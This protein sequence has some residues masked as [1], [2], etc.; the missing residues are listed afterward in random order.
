VHSTR[1]DRYAVISLDS[2]NES[3]CDCCIQDADSSS[4]LFWC[5]YCLSGDEL[6]YSKSSSLHIYLFGYEFADSLIVITKN[7]F[8]FMATAKKCGFVQEYLSLKHES[9][10]VHVLVRTKDE[11]QNRQH[12]N[13]LAN[14][15]RRNGGKRLGT[16]TKGDFQGQ[17]IPSWMTFV[18]QSQ[19]EKVDIS[20][21][22]GLLLAIKDKEELVRARTEHSP[23]IV[24]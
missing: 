18:E 16:I 21:S 20:S 2:I 14:V 7:N 15:I 1:S 12:F 4:S 11:G 17:F 3:Y 13:D 10:K 9:I 5:T 8:Y 23:Y 24:H 6:N 19:I 22:I